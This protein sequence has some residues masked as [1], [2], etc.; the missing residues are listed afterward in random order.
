MPDGEQHR[1]ELGGNLNVALDSSAIVDACTIV[2]G[3][4]I[5]GGGIA[6]F[7]APAV[8]INRTIVYD[9][10]SGASWLGDGSGLTVTCSDF[11]GNVDG[12]WA[13]I[14]DAMLG[15]DGNIA[16]D[17]LFCAHL[18]GLNPYSLADSSPC[19]E[20]NSGCEGPIGAFGIG[21]SYVAEVPGGKLPTVSRID[22]AYPNP[23]N[24]RTSI[25]YG[26]HRE[27]HVELAVFDISGRLVHRLVSES[28]A[29][30]NYEAVWEGRDG[31]GRNAAAGVYFF[32]LKTA[33]TID[34]KR[35]TLIK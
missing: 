3:G 1:G 6:S 7:D 2:G 13:G 24:P 28:K 32:R 22:A 35:V 31:Q 30:G 18:D 20:A 14:L 21:C 11:Y 17:P 27:G 8:S 34:T 29:A 26:L 16:D 33:D 10:S 23:F 15:A 5:I 19:T 9:G 25:K 4:A 12:D